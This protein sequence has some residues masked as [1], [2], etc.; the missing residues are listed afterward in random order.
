MTPI[1]VTLAAMLTLTGAQ[2]FATTAPAVTDSDGNGSYSLAE[3]QAAF[4]EVTDQTYAK[5]DADG[6][7]TVSPDELAA[8]INDGVLKAQG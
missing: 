7:G 5:I 6:N 1:R 2:A 8:A 4:P 3:I